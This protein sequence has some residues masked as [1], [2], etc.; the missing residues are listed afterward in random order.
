ML[1]FKCID[2]TNIG[3]IYVKTLDTFFKKN[4]IKNIT[5]EDCESI[6][7]RLDLDADYKLN[8]EEFIKGMSAQEPYSKMI[9]RTAI[10]KEENFG[11]D[12]EK[13]KE[14]QIK[15]GN[16]RPKKPEAVKAHNEM[17]STVFNQK[18]RLDRD[19]LD[20]SGV[21][22][23]KNRHEIDLYGLKSGLGKFN[24]IMVENINKIPE[25]EEYED[26]ATL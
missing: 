24:P 4:F 12:Y 25:P 13:W 2:S 9:I 18:Q 14:S 21:S 16:K 10:K 23:I 3:F 26:K 19:Y 20:V 1:S 5:M 17:M 15:A 22:P 11:K 8:P 7:R 6:I